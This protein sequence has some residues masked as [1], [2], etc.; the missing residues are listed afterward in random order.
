VQLKMRLIIWDAGMAL[1]W[2]AIDDRGEIRAV[3]QNARG[4]A[5]SPDR[6]PIWRFDIIGREKPTALKRA[7]YSTAEDA[8]DAVRAKLGC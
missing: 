7:Y 6:E 1:V 8:L 5:N 2:H 4:S 3:I